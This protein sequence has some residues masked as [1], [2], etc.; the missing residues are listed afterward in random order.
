MDNGW[1]RSAS[2]WIAAMGEQGD[3]G[4][5]HVLDPIM[6][7]CAS[8]AAIRTCARR[9]LRGRTVLPDAPGERH[10]CCWNR[11]YR[12][13]ARSGKK[14]RCEGRIPNRKGRELALSRRQFRS[15]RKLSNAD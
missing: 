9:R 7:K 4:R 15:R 12:G 6:L 8:A 2:S 1:D 11:P 13:F 3:W 14:T 5:E 10:P